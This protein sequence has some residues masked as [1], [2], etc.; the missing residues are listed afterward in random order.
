M[1]KVKPY[2]IT[3]KFIGFYEDPRP[4]VDQI[5]NEINM[6]ALEITI[7]DA[8][9]TAAP[10]VVKPAV[11]ID[12]ESRTISYFPAEQAAAVPAATEAP[13]AAA[14]S[15]DLFSKNEAPFDTYDLD[16]SGPSMKILSLLYKS[17]K[18]GRT[19]RE[20]REVTKLTGTSANTTTS[21]LKA[22]GRVKVIGVNG[23]GESIYGFV[24]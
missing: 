1:A 12:V 3:V 13:A 6:D 17:G 22:R 15:V 10:K 4:T 18:K 5:A 11:E 2:I 19:M 24:K 14:A 23:E 16:R 8:I 21:R 20:I 7:E 9:V